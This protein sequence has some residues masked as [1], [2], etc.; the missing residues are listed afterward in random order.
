MKNL[1]TEEKGKVVEFFQEQVEARSF[2]ERTLPFFGIMFVLFS[3]SDLA[4]FPLLLIS[5]IVLNFAWF[6]IITPKRIS[7]LSVIRLPVLY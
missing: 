5:C 7:N 2:K 6:R 4:N 3:L 1:T